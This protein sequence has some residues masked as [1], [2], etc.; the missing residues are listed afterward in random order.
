[1]NYLWLFL[2]QKLPQIPVIALFHTVTPANVIG[3][4]G[5]SVVVDGVAQYLRT[6][7]SRRLASAVK[8]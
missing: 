5:N 3:F 7:G 8:T 6:L 1:M 2:T 4:I